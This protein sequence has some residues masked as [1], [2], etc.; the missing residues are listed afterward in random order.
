MSES[1]EGLPAETWDVFGGNTPELDFW[2]FE[3]TLKKRGGLTLDLTCGS[4]K[5]LVPYIE[6]GLAVHGVDS[7]PTMI[8]N[9]RARLES[10]GLHTELFCQKMQDLS[11]PYHYDTIFVSVGSFCVLTSL[12]D[13]HET[14][15]R[16]F[17]HL[18]AAGLLYVT[19]FLPTE[20]KN[21][22]DFTR[23][24][25]GPKPFGAAT[26]AEIERWTESVDHFNQLVVQRRRYRVRRGA[27]I[28]REEA[29]TSSLRWYGKNEF[30]L[31]LERA[32]F[33][34]I[35]CFGNF[36]EETATQWDP[37]VVYCARRP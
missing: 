37:M 15:R 33:D 31:M 24:T 3:A 26:T 21:T 22:A 7:S 9:C 19:L 2:F 8:A 13:A 34:Q 35:R 1:Y 6:Q 5:H 28:L 10:K 20:A 11:L 12:D 16:C 30:T 23:F 36:R 29:Y 18:K 32:G 17:D 4:G 14:L 27:E 25:L